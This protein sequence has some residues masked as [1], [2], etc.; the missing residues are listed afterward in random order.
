MSS[1]RKLW[2]RRRGACNKVK[3]LSHFLKNFNIWG[4]GSEFTLAIRGPQGHRLTL[5][6]RARTDAYWT[7]SVSVLLPSRDMRFLFASNGHAPR[8]DTLP[9]PAQTS[10]CVSSSLSSLSRAQQQPQRTAV[11]RQRR[12][13]RRRR[14]R[15]GRRWRQRRRFRRIN[16][17]RATASAKT[18]S[19]AIHGVAVQQ[20]ARPLPSFSGQR[21]PFP[22]RESDDDDDSTGYTTDKQSDDEG[23]G[24][25]AA[26]ACDGDG[27]GDGDGDRLRCVTTADTI[28]DKSAVATT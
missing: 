2:R 5:F 11:R 18:T 24:A 19:G 7:R 3:Y 9:P 20:R 26:A 6:S 17:R 28:D 13:R 1:A 10:L 15:C 4:E 14:R 23:D 25:A 21:P 27:D 8:T 12:R 22:R 16:P